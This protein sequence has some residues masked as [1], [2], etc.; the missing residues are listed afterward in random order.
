VRWV[1]GSVAVLGASITCVGAWK[2]WQIKPGDRR[3]SLTAGIIM[4]MPTTGLV[5]Y[6]ADTKRAMAIVLVGSA[7]QLV[8]AILALLA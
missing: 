4:G 2:L 8:A 3:Y 5:N 7:L 6:L 1:A